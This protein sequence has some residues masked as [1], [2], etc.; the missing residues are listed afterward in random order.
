MQSC[1]QKIHLSNLRPISFCSW[2][3][4]SIAV[5]IGKISKPVSQRHWFEDTSP[6]PGSLAFKRVKH[7]WQGFLILACLWCQVSV[8]AFVISG[9]RFRT[10]LFERLPGLLPW[11]C[12]RKQ[13]FTNCSSR[14]IF[15]F[16]PP[17]L[18]AFTFTPSP[19]L[20]PHLLSLVV[21]IDM[22][23]WES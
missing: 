21:R 5:L 13:A 19:L 16:L 8:L 10:P 1:S 18:V 23:D 12:G 3:L 2:N 20:D 14:H 22:R 6:L 9:G 17:S 11:C 15:Q 4:I 7:G